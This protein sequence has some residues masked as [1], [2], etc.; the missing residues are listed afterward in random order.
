M[1][2]VQLDLKNFVGE[3]EG[4]KELPLSELQYKVLLTVEEANRLFGLGICSL[5][6]RMRE[7]RCP[8]SIKV[9]DKKQLI[10]RQKLEQY[11]HEHKRF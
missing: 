1:R 5:R 2:V 6:E 11:I 10:D 3:S 9:G 8:F 4:E 7:P